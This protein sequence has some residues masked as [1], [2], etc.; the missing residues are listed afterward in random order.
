MTDLHAEV[1]AVFRDAQLGYDPAFIFDDD[2]RATGE[3]STIDAATHRSVEIF[4]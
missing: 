2:E 4:D 3:W 1:L